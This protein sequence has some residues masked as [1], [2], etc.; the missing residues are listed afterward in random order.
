MTAV[1]AGTL[2]CGMKLTHDGG[3]AVVDGNRLVVSIEA[4][5]LENRER[6]APM[7]RAADLNHQLSV[8]GIAAE[9]VRA[10]VDGWARGAQN[11]TWVEVHDDAGTPHPVEVAGYHDDPGA[12]GLLTGVEGL[13]PLFG[14]QA[15]AFRSFS[16][17]TDHA[18]AA[19]CTSPFAAAQ[20]PALVTVW[21]GGMVPMIYLADPRHGRL[22]C[23]GP[24]GRISG[25]LFP[26]FSS[27]FD[28]FR[29]NHAARMSEQSGPGLEALLPIAG[30][31]MAYASLDAVSEPAIAV[32]RAATDEFPLIDAAIPAYLW[33]R[34]VIQRAAPLKLSDPA[35]IGSLQEFLYRHLSESLDALLLGRPDLRGLPICMSG[36]CALNIKWNSGLRSSGRFPAVWVPPFPNDSGSAIGAACTEMARGGAGWGLEWSVFAGPGAVRTGAP[37][38]GWTAS[39]C[40]IEE[41]AKILEAEGEPVVVVDGPA[42]L[43]PRALGHRSI[44]AP[45]TSPRMKDR[46]ND[47]KNREPYR[48]VAPICLVHRA[49][50]IFDPGTEDPY[51]LFDHQIRPEWL[52]RIPAVAHVDESARLQ[53]VG[54]DNDLMWRL[55]TAYEELTGVPVLCNTS[56]NLKGS[57]FFPDAASAMRWGG[58]RRVWSDGTLYTADAG[59]PQD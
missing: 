39:A 52:H 29:V 2:V 58:V 57:G 32:M 37:E 7:N 20:E 46:L 5:K 8:L 25:A 21:D 23:V 44:I 4:E 49:P 28:A 3:L 24:V 55:L 38:P 6:H 43:G 13:A 14:P 11:E 30:K 33:S 15:T 18:M 41:L 1:P 45:A 36:G 9:D 54:P 35:L 31:A 50:E 22:E 34:R 51:M 47:I 10:C 42:E 16:H 53:T 26:I 59:D 40:G 48:P 12:G 19:Y 56:A 17:G 27:H